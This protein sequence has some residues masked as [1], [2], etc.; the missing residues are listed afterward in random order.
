MTKSLVR[1]SCNTNLYIA[2]HDIWQYTGGLLLMI[3]VKMRSNQSQ[4]V[5]KLSFCAMS[6][7]LLGGCMSTGTDYRPV[8]D[9]NELAHYES[10]LSHCQTL[11]RNEANA[12]SE[13]KSDAILGAVIGTIAGL[14]EGAEEAIAGAAIGALVGGGIGAHSDAK[15]NRQNVIQCMQGK[16]YNVIASED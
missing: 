14:A 11:A 2:T 6:A 10:D 5:K 3:L 12:S 8:V 4:R 9:G 7:L 13:T 16:G 15:Q 1:E